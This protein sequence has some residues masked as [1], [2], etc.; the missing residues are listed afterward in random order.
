MTSKL[1]LSAGGV[2][3]SHGRTYFNLIA[4]LPG[5]SALKRQISRPP[6]PINEVLGRSYFDPRSLT[7]LLSNDPSI[8]QL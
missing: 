6:A 5:L 1:R 2:F 8:R 3:F 7:M 4:V